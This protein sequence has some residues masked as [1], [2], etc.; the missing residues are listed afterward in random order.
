MYIFIE[1]IWRGVAPYLRLAIVVI[2]IIIR[3]ATRTV[4]RTSSGFP[5]SEL[6]PPSSPIFLVFAAELV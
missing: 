3:L 1:K 2:I 5:K 6:R 4:P